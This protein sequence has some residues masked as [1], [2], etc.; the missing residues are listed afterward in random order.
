MKL[1]V[2]CELTGE[3]GVVFTYKLR[4]ERISSKLRPFKFMI[5]IF[6]EKFTSIFF[7]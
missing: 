4:N 6:T 5:Y 7:W 1:Y 2:T 3:M